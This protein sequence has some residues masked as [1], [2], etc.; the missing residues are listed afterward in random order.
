MQST[1]K[2][3][4]KSGMY[5][6]I[7]SGPYMINEVDPGSK[8]VLKRNPDYWGKDLPI[9]VGK[10]N[11]DEIQIEYYRDG[12]AMFEA[13]KKGKFD[14]QPESDPARW[15][16]QYDFNA[17]EKGGRRKKGLSVQSTY[18]HVGLC[19]QYA[20]NPFFKTALFGARWRRYLISI[21]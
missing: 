21:G 15:A 4:R 2:N 18:R 6:F 9:K 14:L 7:G 12:T 11:F 5:Q 16:D 1:R 19:F 20:A 8:I 17:V 10:D 3:S 13:F